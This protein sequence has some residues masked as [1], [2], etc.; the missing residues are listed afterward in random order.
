MPNIRLYGLEALLN[1]I[2]LSLPIFDLAVHI[3]HF[4]SIQLL[5]LGLDLLVLPID[6]VG[7]V[8]QQLTLPDR[9]FLDL[10]LLFLQDVVHLNRCYLKVLPSLEH[11]SSVERR[12]CNGSNVHVLLLDPLD[13]L[14]DVLLGIFDLIEVL[15]H[16]CHFLH[17]L[18]L[19]LELAHHVADVLLHLLTFQLY[20]VLDEID[21]AFDV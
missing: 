20:G 15:D 1:L 8:L 19:A 13:L 3:K 10:V 14:K 5:A 21:D 16:L 9:I 17:V 18:R 2:P 12:T 6:L 4:L 7:L 11:V